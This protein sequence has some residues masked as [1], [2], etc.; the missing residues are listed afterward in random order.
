MNWAIDSDADRLYYST[1]NGSSWSSAVTVSGTNGEYTIEGLTA[2]TSYN[3]L[4]KFRRAATQS[5]TTVASATAVTTYDYPTPLNAPNFTIGKPITLNF[6]NPLSRH[7]ILT[8]IGDDGRTILYTGIDGATY[9]GG[10]G[11]GSVTAQYAS[12]PNKQKGSYKVQLTYNNVTKEYGTGTYKIRGDEKPTFT[13]FDYEDVDAR[14]PTLTGSN[15]ITV[16]NYSDAKITV[17]V[18]NKAVANNSASMVKYRFK[19]GNTVVEQPYISDD[20]VVAT[21]NNMTSHTI[22]VTAVDSRGLET[23][24]R[25]ETPMKNYT[26]MTYTKAKITRENGVGTTGLIDIVGTYWNGNFGATVNSIYTVRV[27]VAKI[28]DDYPQNY[29]EITNQFTTGS[30]EFETNSNAYIPVS[31]GSTDP[32]EFELGKEY[33]IFILVRDQLGTSSSQTIEIFLDSGIPCTDKVK[34]SNGTYNI[35]INQLADDD[36]ALAITGGLKVDDVKIIG[37]VASLTNSQNQEFATTATWV[38]T[39][40]EFDTI[41]STTSAFTLSNNGVKIGKGISKILVSGAFT[42]NGYVSAG[43]LQI[44]I[45]KNGTVTG[46]YF[47]QTIQ[48]SWSHITL[49]MPPQPI[50]VRENDVTDIK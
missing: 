22:S 20:K 33:K 39:N 47:R 8:L 40:V 5:N 27:Y 35:G 13:T 7:A 41:D 38:A 15:Q 37:G 49:T 42:T 28:G 2:N 4:L 6:Y 1:D 44:G 32:Y 23:T 16:R 21:I 36:V 18:A 31:T 9:T 50:D 24:V 26:N 30:G 12:I 14:T 3:V 46:K 10:N 34:N 11:S 29:I 17:S 25:I 45:G 43:A 48:T 19:I